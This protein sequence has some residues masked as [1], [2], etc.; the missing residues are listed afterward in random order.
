MKLKTFQDDK[1]IYYTDLLKFER[2]FES[3]LNQTKLD[4][5]E[6]IIEKQSKIKNFE[7]D[8]KTLSQDYFKESENFKKILK[9]IKKNDVGSEE[10][11]KITVLLYLAESNSKSF[12]NNQKSNASNPKVSAEKIDL[13]A[14]AASKNLKYSESE[15]SEFIGNLNNNE[16]IKQ[17]YVVENLKSKINSS[18]NENIENNLNKCEL[19][20]TFK[21][22]DAVAHNYTTN[23]KKFMD[24]YINNYKVNFQK[25]NYIFKI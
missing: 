1:A 10:Y 2:S 14:Y 6:K 18:F 3:D 19:E 17:Y 5:L 23:K 9:S 7:K 25:I 11:E 12:F 8:M 4:L 22:Y 13:F 15:I 16:I 24:D 20:K 21:K